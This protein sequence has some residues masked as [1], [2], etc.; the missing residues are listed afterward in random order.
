MLREMVVMAAFLLALSGIAAGIVII[1]KTA[2][3]QT[4]KAER[5]MEYAN[6]I[7]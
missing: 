1:Q 5:V 7:D 3:T 4:A 2:S 6:E